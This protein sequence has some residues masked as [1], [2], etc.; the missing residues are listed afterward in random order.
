MS[1][2]VRKT[3]VIPRKPLVCWRG[4][5]DPE[6][7]CAWVPGLRS[8]TVLEKQA[9]GLP[10]LVEFELATGRRYTLSYSYPATDVAK[11]CRWTPIMGA[12][13]AV[14]GFAR[15]EPSEDGGTRLTYE[16][17]HG[18]SRSDLERAVAS[19]DEVLDAFTWWIEELQERPPAR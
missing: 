6:T 13:D 19:A 17:E 1:F 3:I 12:E 8:A 11:I 5:T 7:L 16:L 10:S 15:F 18:P 2:V 9:D 14:R 4:F